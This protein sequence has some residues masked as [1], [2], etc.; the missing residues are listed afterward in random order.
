MTKALSE[1]IDSIE[2][3]F[4]KKDGSTSTDFP[5][6]DVEVS[7]LVFDSRDVKK[8]YLFFALPGTHTTGN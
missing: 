3:T 5:A 8:G 7:N 1:F 6:K 2:Y 4:V